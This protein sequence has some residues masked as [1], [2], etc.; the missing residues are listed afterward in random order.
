[1]HASHYM[2]SRMVFSEVVK[3]RF[4]EREL[5]KQLLRLECSGLGLLAEGGGE[6]VT[7]R[8]VLQNVVGPSPF[9]FIR[10][11][12]TTWDLARAIEI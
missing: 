11:T 7:C 2:L 8:T 4:G 1:M 5:W 10:H 9:A 6:E 12:C 3:L